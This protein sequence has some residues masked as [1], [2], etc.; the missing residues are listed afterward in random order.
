MWNEH[1]IVRWIFW[2]VY[3]RPNNGVK[4]LNMERKYTN[5]TKQNNHKI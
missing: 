2:N 5:M 1:N 4:S 3:D